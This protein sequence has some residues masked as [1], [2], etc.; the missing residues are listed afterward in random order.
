MV[1]CVVPN[2]PIVLVGKVHKCY[3]LALAEV[4]GRGLVLLIMNSNRYIF[5]SGFS[6]LSAGISFSSVAPCLLD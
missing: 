6:S 1:V 2:V 3:F 4:V 5:F